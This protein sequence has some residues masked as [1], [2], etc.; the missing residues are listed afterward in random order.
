VVQDAN[1]VSG[2]TGDKLLVDSFL[3]AVGLICTCLAVSD[4]PLAFSAAS[5]SGLLGL[6]NFGEPFEI[7]G[8]ADR[9]RDELGGFA[10]QVAE[11]KQT[12]VDTNAGTWTG[13]ARDEFQGY[14]DHM[15]NIAGAFDA[16]SSMTY[17]EL[18]WFALSVVASDVAIIVFAFAVAAILVSLLPGLVPVGETEPVIGAT[19]VSYLQALAIFAGDILLLE[20]A[21]RFLSHNVQSAADG[22]TAKLWQHGERDGK[23][24]LS[25][26]SA[27]MPIPPVSQWE[28]DPSLDRLGR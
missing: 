1:D 20:E 26:N 24:P 2:S 13:V 4:P 5:M 16:A 19:A 6:T 10:D 28:Y 3:A 15:Q 8:A 23:D 7:F 12:F 11:L 27:V 25:N 14:L 9:W 21:G 18:Q 22:L 17:N